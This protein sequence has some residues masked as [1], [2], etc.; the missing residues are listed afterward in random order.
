MKDGKQIAFEVETGNSDAV[1]NIKK[2]L[3]AGLDRVVVVATSREFYGRLQDAL[4]RDRRVKLIT[5]SELFAPRR[6]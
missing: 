2:C 1:G 3:D 5:A 6:R 4:T